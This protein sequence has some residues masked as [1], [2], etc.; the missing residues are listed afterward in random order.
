[1]SDSSCLFFVR[2]MS[3]VVYLYNGKQENRNGFI[4]V[5]P[6]GIYPAVPW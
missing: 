3:A 6:D 5:Q 4:T 1:M 2:S